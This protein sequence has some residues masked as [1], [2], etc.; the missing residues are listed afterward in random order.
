MLRPDQPVRWSAPLGGG[1]HQGPSISFSIGP[2][3]PPNRR[4][5]LG[6]IGHDLRALNPARTFLDLRVILR[7]SRPHPGLDHP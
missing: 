4:Q 7:L 6:S 5:R 2:I 1:I 3:D